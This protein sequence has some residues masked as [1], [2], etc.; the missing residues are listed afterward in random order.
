MDRDVIPEK[1]SSSRCINSPEVQHPSEL[2]SH[3]SRV[4][5]HLSQGGRYPFPSLSL[6]R[7]FEVHL[8]NG[9]CSPTWQYAPFESPTRIVRAMGQ[10]G[11]RMFQAPWRHP[12]LDQWRSRQKSRNNHCTV[13]RGRMA[14]LG[15]Q[16]SCR[17]KLEGESV[18]EQQDRRFFD[19]DQWC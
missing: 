8:G 11:S 10:D 19:R 6:T 5:S 2:T 1:L 14:K 9:R 17:S 13:W 4:T 15:Y 12:T 18:D 16:M 3:A 7:C